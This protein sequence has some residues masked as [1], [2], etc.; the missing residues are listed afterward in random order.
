MTTMPSVPGAA[1]PE[2]HSS[3]HASDDVTAHDTKML[4]ERHAR[5]E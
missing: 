2:E 5:A 1:Q 3:L 4:C